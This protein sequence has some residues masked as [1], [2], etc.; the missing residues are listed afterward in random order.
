[1]IKIIDGVGEKEHVTAEDVALSQI[2]TIGD[3]KSVV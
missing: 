3:R 2:G 1:M